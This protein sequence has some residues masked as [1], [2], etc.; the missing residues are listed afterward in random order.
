[1]KAIGLYKYLPIEDTQSLVDVDLEIPKPGEHDLI[2]EVKAV[3]VN[4]ADTKVRRSGTQTETTPRIL[5]WDVAG[6]VKEVGSEASLFKPGDEV[7]YSG[8]WNRPGAYS[9]FHLVDQRLVGPKP[10]SLSFAEAAALPLTTITAWEGLFERLLISQEPA[11]NKGKT[12]LIINAAGGVGSMATQLAHWAGLTVIGTASRPESTEW[13]KKM[14]ATHIIDH[15]Q[16]LEPQIGELG[17]KTVD[18]IFLLKNV[19]QHW[20]ASVDLIAPQGKICLVDDPYE[21]LDL[22][23]VH[24]K[25]VSVT[26]ENVFTR[27]NFRTADMEEQHRLLAKVAELID[28]GVLQTTLTKRLSPITANTLREAHAKV[29]AGSMIGKVVLEGFPK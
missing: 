16:P 12:I 28:A 24:S 21:L 17:Y 29:E 7:Y 5:G 4:P 18:A 23:K 19:S 22:R 14:G 8:E 2:V 15:R 20:D 13:V 10:K 6:V 9:E 27:P 1:V 25:S 26:T 3:G 11:K